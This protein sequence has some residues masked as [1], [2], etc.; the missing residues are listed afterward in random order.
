MEESS[1]ES[2]NKKRKAIISNGGLENFWEE[3]QIPSQSSNDN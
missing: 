2:N 3:F 1:G